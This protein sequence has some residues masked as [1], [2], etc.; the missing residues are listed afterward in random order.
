MSLPT[1]TPPV[2]AS[3]GD[4]FG[5]DIESLLN[6]PPV[7]MDLDAV[8]VEPGPYCMS[9]GFDLE[10]LIGSIARFGLLSTPCVTKGAKGPKDVVTG[11]RRLHA[12]KALG[13]HRVPVRDLSRGRLP[14]VNCLLLNLSDNLTTRELNDVEK[15]MFL[16]RL[17]VLVQREEILTRYMPLLG[18]PRK[19]PLLETYLRIEE[20]DHEIKTSLARAEL[21][22]R[23]VKHLQEMDQGSRTVV[24]EWLSTMK[25]NF[26][27]QNQFIDH[28]IDIS[29]KNRMS[30]T[31]LFDEKV[32]QAIRHDK[33]LNLPQKARKLLEHLHARRL[34]RLRRAENA[35]QRTV[36]DLRL[37]PGVRV[38]H[39]PYFEG[40]TYRLEVLFET[41]QM[42]REKI[43]H[44]SQLEGLEN[45]GDPW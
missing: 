4:R 35:F 12:W 39:P 44:L 10:G 1:K 29:I 41:G 14:A 5:P 24:F 26:N 16:K 23:T 19:E 22:L 7:M 13:R 20:L 30:M 18:L 15:G 17:S 33:H 37:P 34:P 42:L 38:F 3:G 40:S 43:N 45:I 36:N 6:E 8:D 2:F 25:F 11:Y 28:I 27:Q 31:N 21:S 9:F 32:V